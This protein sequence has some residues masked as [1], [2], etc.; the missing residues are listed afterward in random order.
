MERALMLWLLV[1][2]YARVPAILTT[3]PVPTHHSR[4]GPGLDLFIFLA[5]TQFTSA[6]RGGGG[7][8]DGGGE[9]I[10]PPPPTSS[11]L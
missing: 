2:T 4:L 1:I 10:L 8:G 7:G 3:F 11:S 5:V 9:A 6:G